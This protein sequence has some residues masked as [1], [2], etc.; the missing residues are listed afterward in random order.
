MEQH[1]KALICKAGLSL[2][3]SRRK[4]QETTKLVVKAVLSGFRAIDTGLSMRHTIILARDSCLYAS[5]P[6]EALS[7]GLG[8]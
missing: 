6:A 3:L 8:W 2:T 7:R 4:K 1:G 5:C